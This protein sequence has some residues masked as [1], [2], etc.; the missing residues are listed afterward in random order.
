MDIDPQ[1]AP[2]LGFPKSEY[3]AIERE[4]RWLCR[5]VP[6]DRILRSEAITDLYVTGTRLRLREARPTNGAAPMLRLSRKADIDSR[7]R[8]IT[9]IYLSEDEFAVLA[10]SLPGIRIR[11]LRHR[12]GRAAGVE[13][14]V[15]EFQDELAGLILAEAQFD[16]PARMASFAMPA[17]ALR[18]V[19]DDERFTGGRLV[20][21]GIPSA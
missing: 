7:T 16:T 3:I 4:R 15:D 8:L 21:D 10:C 19:T 1:I 9:S 11:K 13:M 17:F 14:L 6:A 20:K 5:A 12:L 18:E 2:A